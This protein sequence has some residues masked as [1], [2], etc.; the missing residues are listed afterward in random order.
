M[1]SVRKKRS[2]HRWG[3]CSDPRS[4]WA[5]AGWKDIIVKRILALAVATTALFVISIPAALAAVIEIPV[6]TV[7]EAD[8]GSTTV[9]ATIDTDPE[10]IGESCAVS[11]RAMNQESTHPGNDLIVASDGTSI[12][13]SDVERTPDAVT[14][15]TGTLT[16]G[17]TIT[18]S[19]HMGADG[20]FSGGVVVTGECPPP[21]PPVIIIEKTATPETYGDDGIGHF[22]IEVTNPGPVDLTEVHVTDDV[23]LAVDPTS[24]CAQD[25]LPDLAVGD[26]YTYE[27][28]IANLDGVSP[29]TNEATA[30]GTGP[31][32]RRAT[33]TDD[34]TVFPPVVPTTVTTPPTTMPPT[35]VP[36]TLPNT[37][38][39][40]EQVRGVSATAVAFLFAGIALLAAAAWIGRYRLA[41]AL[42]YFEIYIDLEPRSADRTIY[43]P[44]RRND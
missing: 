27:C 18:V 9:L 24:D 25:A 26:S 20:V 4:R 29:F 19:L 7:V 21:T 39:S 37:G 32:G 5:P 10:L 6:D 33:D 35:T 42:G 28:S 36:P 8:P 44:L 16:L 30:I 2:G 31:D 1:G 13:L 15:A 40:F 43:I 12:T 11:A 14:N 3:E 41:Q 23:A 38:A 22:T 34:A 17:P